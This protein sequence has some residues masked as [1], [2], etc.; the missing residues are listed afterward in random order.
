[1]Q[2]GVWWRLMWATRRDKLART[3]RLY[4]HTPKHLNKNKL[5]NRLIYDEFVTSA[6]K[7]DNEVNWSWIYRR[8]KGVK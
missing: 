4:N 7:Y 8:I 6:I 5:K 2:K 3:M 1:M